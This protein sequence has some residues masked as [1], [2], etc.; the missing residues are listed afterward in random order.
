MVGLEQWQASSACPARPA[1]PAKTWPLTGSGSFATELADVFMARLA[2][3]FRGTK[4]KDRIKGDPV[5][6]EENIT[7]CKSPN[8]KSC[9]NYTN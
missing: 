6:V 9:I 7:D 5:L 1:C 4:R 3:C 2:P 8:L